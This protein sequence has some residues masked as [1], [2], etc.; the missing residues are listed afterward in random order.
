MEEKRFLL[1]SIYFDFV[2]I[3]LFVFFIIFFVPETRGLSLEEIEIL[4]TG[5]PI[6]RAQLSPIESYH[7]VSSIANLKATPS[8]IL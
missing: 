1:E 5:K 8:I 4:Y 2:V 3:F 6:R 7:R